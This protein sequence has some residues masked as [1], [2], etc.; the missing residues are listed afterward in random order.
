MTAQEPN[1]LPKRLQ[2]IIEV[3]SNQLIAEQIKLTDSR[4]R[5]SSMSPLDLS[6][7]S[8]GLTIISLC[9]NVGLSLLGRLDG[10]DSDS[11][12]HPDHNW[13]SLS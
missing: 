12:H 1:Y 3:Q 2:G 9:V 6:L 5:K 13:P 4:I 10:P 8:S 7:P 11:G